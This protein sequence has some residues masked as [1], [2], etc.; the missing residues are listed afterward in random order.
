MKGEFNKMKSYFGF[1]I[2]FLVLM[3]VYLFM[4]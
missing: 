3:L 2:F 1:F 4:F